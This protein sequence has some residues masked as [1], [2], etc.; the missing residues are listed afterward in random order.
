MAYKPFHTV[1]EAMVCQHFLQ[2]TDPS[3]I[4]LQRDGSARPCILSSLLEECGS[5]TPRQEIEDGIVSAAGTAYEGVSAIHYSS[6]LGRQ[7]VF[8]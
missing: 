1:K 6:Q 4:V 3:L 7:F 8:L 2:V 5:E